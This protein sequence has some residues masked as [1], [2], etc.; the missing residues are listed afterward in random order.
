MRIMQGLRQMIYV[1]T[2]ERLFKYLYVW[3]TQNPLQLDPMLSRGDN[4]IANAQGD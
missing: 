2:V 4:S 1:V 3:Q